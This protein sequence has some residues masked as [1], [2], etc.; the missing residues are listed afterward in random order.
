M[1]TILAMTSYFKG[2]ALLEAAKKEGARVI[3]LTVESL[4]NDNWPRGSVDEFFLMPSLSKLP[5]TVFAVAYLARNEDLARIIP[6]GEYDVEMAAILREHLRMP[7]MGT[8][9]TKNFRDKLAM[10]QVAH[11]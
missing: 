2:E 10:R 4:K 7:G 8:T 5:D 6:L 9:A 11:D 3:L 1:T